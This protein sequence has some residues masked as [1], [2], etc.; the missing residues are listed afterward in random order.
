QELDTFA[1]EQL[2]TAVVAFDVLLAATGQRFAVLLG[3][4]GDA[5]GHSIAVRRV[6]LRRS[7]DRCL[8]SCHAAPLVALD[9]RSFLTAP[10]PLRTPGALP[11]GR[12]TPRSY[13][14]RYRGCVHRDRDARPR[15]RVRTRLRRRSV[16]PRRRR[17]RMPAPRCSSRYSRPA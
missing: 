15:T 1:R 8:E 13:R 9:A 16:R 2:A 7:V 3:E 5:F 4:V 10:S 14:R 17:S 12:S 11:P 6:R